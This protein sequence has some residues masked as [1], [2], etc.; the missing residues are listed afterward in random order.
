MTLCDGPLG[1]PLL[2]SKDVLPLAGLRFRLSCIPPTT[3]HHAKRIVRLGRFSRLADKPELVGAK[4]TLEA[5]LLP[6]QPAS[7]VPGPVA[8]TVHWTWPWLKGHSKRDRALGLKL[9]TSK[10]DLTNVMKTLEDRLVR[11]RFIEDDRSVA[12]LSLTKHWGDVPGIAIE[13]VS[14]A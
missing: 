13:I 7:P 3:T 6:F 2:R 8:L 9:H 11:L 12:R 4:Q 14:L 5:L 10:P 1:V